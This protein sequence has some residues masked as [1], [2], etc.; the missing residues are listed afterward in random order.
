MWLLKP[1]GGEPWVDLL[2]R[3]PDLDL[4]K[5]LW[6]QLDPQLGRKLEH[7]SHEKHERKHCIELG[8]RQLDWVQRFVERCD[9]QLVLQQ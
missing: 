3:Q 8:W 6:K 4:G 5:C 9:G 1:R 2:D 7:H